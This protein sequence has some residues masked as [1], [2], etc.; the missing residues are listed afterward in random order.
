MSSASV[1]FQPFRVLIAGGGVAALEAALAL[2]ELAGER[3]S[4]TLLAPE[5]EFVYRPMTVREPFAY[6]VAERYPIGEVA[7]DLGVELRTDSFKGLDASGRVVH[8]EAGAQLGYDALL[9]AL[10]ARAQPRYPA[11]I[12]IDDKRLD[13]VLHGLIQDVEGGYV[14]NLAFVVPGRMG[15][16]LPVYELALMTARRAYEMNIDLAV[17]IATP[18]DAPLAIF[19]DAV[20][21]AVATLLEQNGITMI[22]SAY[23]EVPDS[24]H[25]EIH[26]GDRQLEVNRVV[27][28]PEL[29][30]P[31][32]EG[33]PEDE[34]GFI[35]IDVHCQVP[36]VDRVY[37]AGDATDFAVKHGG[38]AAQ[39]ADAAAE[40]IAALAGAPID[41]QPF[42]PVL[43][44]ILLGGD[45]P[46]YLS[47]DITGGHGSSSQLS[48]TPTWSPPS[49]IAAK[50]LAPYLDA[51]DRTAGH[52]PA[53]T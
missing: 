25:V 31:S 14:H 1:S 28:L 16:Q 22:T 11:A 18:E 3:V 17:T 36:G 45:K 47:T 6:R 12:T 26:P 19:G 46:L 5:P 27:A 30:G 38:L 51:R 10:G 9:L 39:Q 53:R 7:R 33:L 32:I 37:A 41:P 52:T 40:A 21:A 4:T 8:T 13:E 35:P 2:R 15:W 50:Y 23:C 43:H 44:G 42:H 48:D 49:K 24:F 29:Y 34:Y 20:S